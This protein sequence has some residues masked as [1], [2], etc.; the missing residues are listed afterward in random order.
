MS[1]L[2]RKLD[3]LLA[4]ALGVKIDEVTEAV[5]RWHDEHPYPIE[6]YETESI[7]GGY[8]TLQVPLPKEKDLNEM[9][10]QVN[11]FLDQYS[12]AAAA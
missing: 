3:E 5:G 6:R 4:P 10:D 9:R 1:N 12:E 8:P 7:N 11:A 2:E